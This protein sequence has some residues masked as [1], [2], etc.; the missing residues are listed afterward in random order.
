M[1]LILNATALSQA[2][3]MSQERFSE[4]F[5]AHIRTLGPEQAARVEQVLNE[6]SA[7]QRETPESLVPAILA[8]L[9]PEYGLALAAFDAGDYAEA[10][11]RFAPLREHLDPYLAANTHYF[12]VRAQM[13]LHQF[14]EAEAE[15]SG[16]MEQY[17]ELAKYTPYA[18]HVWYLRACCQYANLHISEAAD[19]LRVMRERFPKLPESVSVGMRQLQLELERRERGT[20]EEV[21]RVMNYT[22]ARLE[23]ADDTPRVRQ[24]Q[25]QVVAMLDK[26]IE[27]AQQREQRQ[28]SSNQGRSG[29]AP[30]QPRSG[31][32]DSVLPAEGSAQ[33]GEQHAA[34]P[35]DPGEMWGRLP[36]L[37]RE[38]ILNSLRE[39]FPTRYR[40]LVEQY[41]RS[42]AEEK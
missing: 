7:A 11:R 37:E 19:T 27:Q 4:A 26:L 14:E 15:L 9:Y 29:A 3:D 10:R 20:L 2:P 25:E 40:Q 34:P 35:A 8:E 5:H 42:L 1:I 6:W 32:Q 12:H 22:A 24:R 39:R 18:R 36:P 23:A 21:A 17:E 30:R 41:Y 13:E 28:Q 33:I 31:A 38:K 16:L